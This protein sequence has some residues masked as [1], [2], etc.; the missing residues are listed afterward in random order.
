MTISSQI[1]KRI[2]Q[3]DGE[4]RC[5]AVDFP[6]LSA[7]E[8]KVYCTDSSGSETE[9]SSQCV[10]DEIEQE[11]IYPTIA[12][13]QDP[14]P[15]GYKITIVRDTTP[16][17]TLHL[18]QQGTLDASALEQGFDKLTLHVQELAE[19][20]KRSIKYPVSSNRTN[21][22]AQTFLTGL[23]NAQTQ[24][25][26]SALNS[27]AETKT[28]LEQTVSDESAA[29][30]QADSNLQTAIN[31][32]Q[33]A[34]STDQQS[35]VN[36]G[37]TSAKVSSYDTHLLNTSNPHS[38][39]KAQVGLGNVDNTADEDKP[40]S[41]A[42]QSA[43]EAKQDMLT[44][45]QQA[46]VNSGVTTSTVAQVQT[47]KEDIAALDAELD[48]DRPWQKPADWIDIRSGAK[49]NSVY[50]L[51]AH[52]E[53]VLSEG[54]YT[55]S[56][57]PKFACYARVQE[58]NT[59]DVFVDGVKVATSASETVTTLD[60]AQL[61]TAGTIAGGHPVTT[62]YNFITHIVRMT[63]T[64]RTDTLNS[65][66][67][68]S[69][70]GQVNQGLLWAHFETSTPMWLT[71]A[72]GAESSKRFP[73]LQAITAKDNKITYTVAA[74]SNQS[75]LYNFASYCTSLVQIPVLEAESTTYKSGG[76]LSFT[77]VPA[78]K[79]II[80]NNNGQ[81]DFAMVNQAYAQTIDIENGLLL[82]STTQTQ[83]DAHN[84]TNLKAL[85]SLN[86]SNST[87]FQAYGLTS[88]G[89]TVLDDSKN[90]SRTLLRFYGTSSSPVRGLKGLTV[91]NSAPFT[92]ASPQI[93]VSY[94][95]LDRAALVNLFN[96]LPT[97]TGGQVC[98]VTG[99]TGASDLTASD[100]AIATAKG[101]TITR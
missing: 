30:A 18:T 9:V 2:Y 67:T 96:S 5:W 70:T 55:I 53:P 45:A 47:N 66:K 40:I 4:S 25:L 65:A 94:T 74:Q 100:L 17:Q 3:A 8:L 29:R 10:L 77:R 86:E 69:I 37:V 48:E 82:A 97:V 59:Y 39:T 23:Q 41:T 49:G 44:T 1:C 87:T 35:A 16:T 33:N 60:W 6:Y 24:A 32:K 56:Q 91:S 89:P 7:A 99:A 62:P 75:G 54:T 31:S 11:I 57:Y 95:G 78:K 71:Y 14:L 52:S 80:K 28:E 73:L 46:A 38:V 27:V 68:S 12:S 72:F 84:M 13:E 43:L 50:F 92:G 21:A 19:Q 76:Y 63:P 90:S 34:L 20:V 15:E 83:T 61:Y 79:I 26:T 22:D 88:L 64:N 58:V 42:T 101:W 36:S 81:E 85:P 98:N 93:N 51:V